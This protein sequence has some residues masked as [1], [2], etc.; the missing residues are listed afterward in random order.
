VKDFPAYGAGEQRS[1]ASGLSR[2]APSSW[3]CNT[4]SFVLHSAAYGGNYLFSCVSGPTHAVGGAVFRVRLTPM[5]RLL[6]SL[7]LLLWGFRNK[8]E[9]KQDLRVFGQTL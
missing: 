1:L 5:L 7:S 6:S 9:V 3:A 8:L 4:M 2:P